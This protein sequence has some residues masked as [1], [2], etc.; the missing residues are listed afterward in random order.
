MRLPVSVRPTKISWRSESGTPTIYGELMAAAFCAS[1]FL[2]S[3]G[4]RWVGRER[5]TFLLVLLL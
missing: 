1:S 2:F 4:V 3:I 5:A